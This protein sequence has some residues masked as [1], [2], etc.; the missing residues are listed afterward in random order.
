MARSWSTGALKVRQPIDGSDKPEFTLVNRLLDDPLDG[1]TASSILSEGIGV[2][3]QHVAAHSDPLP[4]AFEVGLDTLVP[5]ITIYKDK[6]YIVHIELQRPRIADEQ[7]HVQREAAAQVTDLNI[8]WRA[9]LIAP[10]GDLERAVVDGPEGA[11]PSHSGGESD[12][13]AALVA[14]DLDG[15]SGAGAARQPKQVGELPRGHEGHAVGEGRAGKQAGQVFELELSV[16][17]QVKGCPLQGHGAVG[18]AADSVA[19]HLAIALIEPLQKGAPEGARG[20]GEDSRGR[21]LDQG[22]EHSP[23]RARARGPWLSSNGRY[24]GCGTHKRHLTS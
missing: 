24:V 4:P 16:R 7:A 22:A 23:Q 21:G 6:V 12:R 14:A 19:D 5:V 2:I 20:D 11:V 13:P 8:V 9:L 3:Q 10:P 1:V 17:L 15:G 18:V